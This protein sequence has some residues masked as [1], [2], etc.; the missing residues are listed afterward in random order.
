MTEQILW[1]TALD[2]ITAITRD[3]NQTRL[4]L[5]TLLDGDLELPQTDNEERVIT[6]SEN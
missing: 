1:T 4:I 3:E 2:E 6:Q 5:G